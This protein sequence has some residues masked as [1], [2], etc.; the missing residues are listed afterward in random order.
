M[1]EHASIANILN[2]QTNKDKGRQF[3]KRDIPSETFRGNLRADSLG[4]E[5]LNRDLHST[6]DLSDE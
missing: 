5:I 3:F 1:K 6:T 2:N 4:A